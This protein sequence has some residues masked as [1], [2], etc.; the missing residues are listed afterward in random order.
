M[1]VPGLPAFGCTPTMRQAFNLQPRQCSV[2]VNTLFALHNHMLRRRVARLRLSYP[3]AIILEAN[4]FNKLIK[5]A[6]L[7]KSSGELSVHPSK[8]WSSI[9]LDAE[10]LLDVVSH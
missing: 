4:T 8:L 6:R 9:I 3:S 7:P 10:L 2:L 5:V 1:L